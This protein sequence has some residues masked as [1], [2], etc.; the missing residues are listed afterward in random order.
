MLAENNREDDTREDD[1]AK[2]NYSQD[3]RTSRD[4][5]AYE[6]YKKQVAYKRAKEQNICFSWMRGNCQKGSACRFSHTI[7]AFASN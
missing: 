3:T 4:A 2:Y 5:Q 6:T 7:N 1:D